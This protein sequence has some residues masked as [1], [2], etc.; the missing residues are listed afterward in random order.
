V[1]ET[2]SGLMPCFDDIEMRLRRGQQPGLQ[3]RPRPAAG[4]V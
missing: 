3:L 2:I 4:I 1:I